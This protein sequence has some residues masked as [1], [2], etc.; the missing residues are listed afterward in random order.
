[1]RTL[2]SKR[3]H[4]YYIMA[5][6]YRRNSAGVRVMH[7][8]CD[9]LNRSG[10]EAYI[11]TRE[12]NPDLRTPFLNEEQFDY[13]KANHIEPIIIYPEVVSGNPMRGRVVVRYLLN[14]PG[15]LGGGS[16]GSQDILFAYGSGL[17]QEGMP[18][19][20]LLFLPPVDLSIFRPP[21]D[22][23]KRVPGKV[24]YYQGRKR[25]AL[26]DPAL[27]PPD[28]VEITQ[29]Y[30]DSWE[31]LA[32]LFQSCEYF[33]SGE[34][35]ALAAE[36]VLC[37]CVGVVMP[38]EWAQS[39]FCQ[40]E[41]GSFGVAWGTAPDEI[42]RARQTMPLLREQLEKQAEAFWP[43]L[44]HFIEVTQRAAVEKAEQLRIERTTPRKPRIGV[45]TR[46]NLDTA[47]YK[48][49]LGDALGLME[50]VF[51]CHHFKYQSS[52]M[53]DGQ[54]P[55]KSD[56][57]FVEQMDLFIVQRVF[58]FPEYRP[59]L[60]EMIA[61]GKPIVYELD[62]WLLGMPEQHAMH[63]LCQPSFEGIEW[64]LPQCALVTVTTEALAE[65]VRPYNDKV[66]VFP[67]LLASERLVEP[68][69]RQGKITIGFAGTS[70][71][72]KDMA[73]LSAA[74][75]RIYGEY[76]G[77]VRFV[78]WGEVPPGFVGVKDARQVSDFVSYND[79]LRDL[80]E[81]RIDIGIA[82]LLA[83]EF[84]DCKSD[85][86]WLEYSVVGAAAVVSDVE[87]YA[88]LKDSGLATVVENTEQA[89]ID[90]LSELIDKPQLREQRVAAARRHIVEHRLLEH[91]V[92]ELF[93]SLAERLPEHL[94]PEAPVELGRITTRT[95]VE[96]DMEALGVYR[97][98]VKQHNLREVHAE[99]L[100]ERM[101]LAWSQRPMFNLIALAPAGSLERLAES[102]AAMERQLY[103]SWRLIVVS[104]SSVPDPIFT[105]SDQLGWVQLDSLDDDQAVTT[106]INGVI[107]DI[108][109]EWTML[110]PAG[111]QLQPHA[112]VRLGEAIHTHPEWAAIYSDSDIISPM[113][114]RF[115]PAFRP[116]FSID[117]LRS[118]DYIGQA[119]AFS[120]IKLSMIGGFQAYPQAHCYDALL[121]LYEQLGDG[122]IGHVD[123][124]LISLPW[125]D[126]KLDQLGQA[127]RQIALENHAARGGL[128]VKVGEG[129][130]FGTY[131]YE[132]QLLA[133]P[134]VSIVIPTRDKLEYLEPCLESLF[135]LTG[136]QNF[137]VLIVDNRSEQPETF[138]YYQQISARYPGRVQ[139]LDYDAPFNFSAQC[140]LGARAAHGEYLLLLNNDTEVVLESWLERMLATAQQPGVGAVGARL[141]YPEVGKVQHAGIVL[142][143]PGG[144]FSVADHVFEGQD[145]MQGGYQ[146]RSLTM[147][148]YSAVTAACLL[149]EKQIYDAVGGMDE[150]QFKVCFNDVDLCLKI[151]A[152]GL[153]NVY[154]PFVVLYHHHAKSIGR[155]TTDPRHA[156]EA[157]VR[158]REEMEAMLARWMPVLA[159]DPGFNRH[160]SL[161]SKRVDI[162]AQ[163]VVAWDPQL[164]G[165]KRVLGMPVPGGSGEYRLS[166]P[167]SVLQEKGRLDGEIHQPSVGIPS[168][169]ELARQ[170]PDTL[171]LHTG[172]SDYIYDSVSAFRE[173]LPGMRVVFG[174]DDL[175][176][177]T[178]EK[179]NLYD[180][181]KR[182]YPDA[183]QRLR[184]VLKLCD[185]AVVSTEPLAELTAGMVGEVVV[186]PNRL[187]KTIWG[188]LSSQRRAGKKPRVGWIG[189][190]QHRGDLELLY[191][192][193]LQ[194]HEEV[195]WVFMGM[196]LP[197]FR[198]FVAEMHHAVPFGEY[199]P[200]IATLNLDLA[201]A[202]LEVNSFNEAKSNLR[203]LEYGALGWPV[204][205]SDIFPYQTNAA[206]VCRVSNQ[207]TAWV[208]AIRARIYDLDAAEAEGDAL[209]AW[210][211]QHYWLEEHHEDW[212]R[213]LHG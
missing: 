94:R 102:F 200:A 83:S 198:P 3:P 59:V 177:G 137:E 79:Y 53:F 180:H 62:D 132:Y 8:L 72:D 77:Q 2:Y 183:K 156:L 111:F 45:L 76:A 202:P 212:F 57:E 63:N 159:R 196:C 13:Y 142:G 55:F 140:N 161:R 28:A 168:I 152:G 103:R 207:A 185:A 32:D 191:E 50:P 141:L 119:V 85:L 144:M 69:P 93:Q 30:P 201:V 134:L 99:Q 66:L 170:A 213:V 108:P 157:A 135:G 14:R 106:V 27:L 9:A 131:H 47:C 98:W 150:Q 154:N 120:T 86:K 175:V 117:Y 17:V 40:E 52:Y 81:L 54:Y 104:D 49:R 61:S 89:W 34:V 29:Q 84:N 189:A 136:Y 56:N 199:A 187:R 164:P 70:T 190:G 192:V 33:Y 206:P 20:Q 123:D 167:L 67:N 124:M 173:Y 174:L 148:N 19:D 91:R 51:D 130:V 6:D 68:L 194:T 122:C 109:A 179:S 125:V 23:A 110:L 166:Q 188:K 24:C 171:L 4:P 48:L 145:F 160:L 78:F 10:Q 128:P 101:M 80:A 208:E 97:R 143:M 38:G 133:Q 96:S 138:E 149:L 16:Y 121:R 153:R 90:A 75:Q 211:R 115:R 100:A 155:V 22:P 114:E 184:R 209:N 43:A 36:A 127:S 147:Q 205:C 151:Q 65:K 7:M 163:R 44:D 182:H 193:I 186:A 169:I 95:T 26:I 88:W 195:E 129:L 31:A 176:G 73:M 21:E 146:N 126:P 71:H 139:V 18:K 107:A 42:E 82:P 60:N 64:L 12:C 165:R 46:D 37:G 39:A 25:Q 105:N 11:T 210:V 113:G 204:V 1:M 181:W 118:M 41:T 158:E 203:L 58:P 15:F 92:G 162:E 112:L 116:D 35:S 172:I 5:P 87:P 197:Q 178:P 74:L